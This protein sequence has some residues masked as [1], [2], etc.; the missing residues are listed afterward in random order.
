MYIHLGGDVVVPDNEIIGVF[1]IENT[2]VS[3]RTKEFLAA[4][5]KNGDIINVS[6]EMPKAY[7]LCER[8]KRQ[9]VYITQVSPLTIR[10][11]SD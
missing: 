9:Q 7:V 6:Y 5:G 11:R 2:S 4:A 10:K 1:D 3:K 8:N